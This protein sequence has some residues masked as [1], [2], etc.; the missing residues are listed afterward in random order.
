MKKLA[1]VALFLAPVLAFA[2][3]APGIYI[4]SVALSHDTVAGGDTVNVTVEVQRV[5]SGC[6][7][8][9]LSTDITVDGVTSTFSYGPLGHTQGSGTESETHTITAPASD[10][11][12]PVT[13]EILNGEESPALGCVSP[14]VQAA[15]T[16]TLTVENPPVE[17]VASHH[18]GG[19]T[20][21]AC[22]YINQIVGKQVCS[23]TPELSAA[24]ADSAIRAALMRLS[25]LHLF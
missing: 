17:K 7:N 25:V 20:A 6:T 9:W 5:G 12:Y 16:T 22:Y 15:T 11:V 23:M 2:A 1:I 10:G 19:N 3:P 8:N 13:V 24:W 14:T 18:S 4:N 21:T